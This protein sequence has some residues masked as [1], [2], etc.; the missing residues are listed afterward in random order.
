MSFDRTIVNVVEFATQ[1]A[2][3]C[4]VVDLAMKNQGDSLVYFEEKCHPLRHY[5]L[6]YNA[7]LDLAHLLTEAAGRK[8][9]ERRR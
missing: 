1:S 5:S 2:Y 8:S 6:A 9:D 4:C 7:L 3:L